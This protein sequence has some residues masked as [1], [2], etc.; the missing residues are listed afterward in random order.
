MKAISLRLP[1]RLHAQLEREAKRQ[2]RSK[3]AVLREVVEQ[4]LKSHPRGNGRRR[5]RPL[6][7]LEAAGD[8]I[9]CVEGPSD[10]STNPKYMEGFGE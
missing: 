2:G 3:S 7:F 9:G 8:L 5:Q 10:L 6:T 1:D 4:S